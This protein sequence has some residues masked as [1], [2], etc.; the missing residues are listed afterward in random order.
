[1]DVIYMQILQRMGTGDGLLCSLQ[2]FTLP[3][4]GYEESYG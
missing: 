1:M 4:Y 2:F 3:E